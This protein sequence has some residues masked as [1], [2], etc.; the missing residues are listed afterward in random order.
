MLLCAW[1][2]NSYETFLL[3]LLIYFFD[4]EMKHRSLTA[5]NFD[6]YHGFLPLSQ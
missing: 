3:T 6:N 2:F 1:I 5:V 4:F